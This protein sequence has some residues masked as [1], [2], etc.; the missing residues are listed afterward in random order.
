MVSGAAYTQKGKV[1]EITPS[2]VEVQ[3]RI[4]SWDADFKP[5]YSDNAY[6]LLHF[7]NSG[8]SYILNPPPGDGWDG[9]GTYE[10]GP[11]ELRTSLPAGFEP[12]G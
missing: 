4:G 9:N 12:A 11:W 10:G 7:D 3:V 2:G 8:R 5:V 1:V 6:E